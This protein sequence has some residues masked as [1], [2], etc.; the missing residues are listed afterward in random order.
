[1]SNSILFPERPD[2]IVVETGLV[3]E[4]IR[5]TLDAHLDP[6]IV[7]WTGQQGMGKT[8]TARRLESMIGS[9]YSTDNP[10]AFR[11]HYFEVGGDVRGSGQRRMKRGIKSLYRQ[12]VGPLDDKVYYREPEEVLGG[13]VREGLRKRRIQMMLVDEA[14]TL[15]VEEIRGMVHVQNLCTEGGWPLSLVL[16]G[17]DDL[18]VKLE[19]LA[20]IRGRI[21]SWCYFEPYEL[22]DTLSIL[23][24]L[25]PHFASLDP[26]QPAGREQIEWVHKEFQGVPRKMIPF[27][28]RLS[29][30]IRDD[31]DDVVDLGFLQAVWA[32]MKMA[33]DRCVAAPGKAYWDFAAPSAS[34]NRAVA[35]NSGLTTET[36]QTR[37]T[38]GRRA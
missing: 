10:N 5:H 14:G 24:A 23:V 38:R 7:V 28:R 1:V 37:V 27:V 21:Q 22:A 3:R 20:H 18:S 26:E 13:F 8:T 9:S 17:M 2:R 16:I 31:P 12:V 32:D 30:R 15:S 25:S 11:A 36:A 19:Q 29:M 6:G 33:H 4:T 35:K 34:T